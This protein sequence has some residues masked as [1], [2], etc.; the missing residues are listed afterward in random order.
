MTDELV[1]KPTP[2]AIDLGLSTASL[3]K[4]GSGWLNLKIT[5]SNKD[6]LKINLDAGTKLTPDW[7]AYG[8]AWAQPTSGTFGGGAGLR[9]KENLDLFVEGEGSVR[10]DMNVI[11][12]IGL[13]F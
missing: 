2:S 6:P 3:F 4:P 10:G 7:A 8:H 13:R 1:E 5:D 12:G 11:A 9:Y